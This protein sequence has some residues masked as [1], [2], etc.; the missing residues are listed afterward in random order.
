MK[1][2]EISEKE[3]ATLYLKRTFSRVPS[4]Q[5]S[6]SIKLGELHSKR[7]SIIFY[8]KSNPPAGQIPVYLVDEAIEQVE[9]EIDKFL[10]IEGRYKSM[11]WNDPYTWIGKEFYCRFHPPGIIT[12][13][14]KANEYGVLFGYLVEGRLIL[15]GCS[16]DE[17]FQDFEY[18]E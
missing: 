8:N 15:G 1:Y 13:V 11:D 10:S 2:P 12:R 18:R 14:E 7:R 16:L 9:K 5:L 4:E 17:F 6:L 3:L